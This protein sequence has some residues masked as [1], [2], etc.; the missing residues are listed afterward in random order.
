M[1]KKLEHNPN[2]LLIQ[3]KPAGD[4]LLLT[5]VFKAIKTKYPSAKVSFLVNEKESLLVKDNPLLDNLILVK[6]FPKKGTANI[7]KYNLYSIS[8]VKKI[9]KMKFDIVID[10][11]GNPKSSIITMFSGS[12]TRI[13]RYLGIRS[14][15]YNYIIEKPFKDTNTVTRR[16]AHLK[17]IGINTEHISPEIFLNKKDKKFGIDYIK[18]LRLTANRKIVIIAP[19]SPRT[20]RRWKADYFAEVGKALI[21]KHKVKILFVWGPGE[22]EY[23][24]TICDNTG[25]DAE[26][27]HLTSLTEMAAIIAKADLMITN[28]SSPKHMANAL[29]VRSIA[30]YGPTNPYV[31]NDIDLGKNPALR[32]DVPCIQCEKRECPFERHICMENLT[33]DIIL[34]KA[35]QILS[36]K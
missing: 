11:I 31:W 35:D 17:P 2:I 26:I 25:F 34:K 23:T 19:N 6:K 10:F 4:V 16:L 32:A 7:F 8:L 28:D 30:I 13:G 33:P 18:S 36:G 15:A 29:G 27:I 5:P 24:K 14:I 12:R 21:K 9:R 1:K 3:F 20:A 22:E